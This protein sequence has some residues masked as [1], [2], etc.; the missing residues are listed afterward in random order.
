S[1]IIG[2]KRAEGDLQVPEG[3]YHI[4]RFNPLSSFHLSLGI[5][6][7]N[8]S[9]K[10]LGKEKPG[11]DIFIHGSDVTVG[12]VPLTDDKIKEVYA[13]AVQARNGGQK[14]IEVHI[15]PFEL[16]DNKLNRH[17]ENPSYTFWKSLQKGYLFF[18]SR[19]KLPKIDVRKDG[20]YDII[21]QK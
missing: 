17:L 21:L 18:E 5:N 9:D 1:G 14:Q 20:I 11:S 10:I 13:L 7:P 12:C 2:P 8:A 4:D 15:F 3:F 6:Y 19:K 16:T